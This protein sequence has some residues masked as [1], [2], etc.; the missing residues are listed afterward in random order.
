MVRRRP[1]CV[2]SL[3]LREPV[4]R[5]GFEHEDVNTKSTTVIAVQSSTHENETLVVAGCPNCFC[6]TTHSIRNSRP[7]T[8]RERDVPSGVDG[9]RDCQNRHLTLKDV[10]DYRQRSSCFRARSTSTAMPSRR[11]RTARTGRAT[12]S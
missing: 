6:S 12:H 2:G 1:K 3:Q 4:D 11:A 7:K 8:V 10:F 5:L 9:Q